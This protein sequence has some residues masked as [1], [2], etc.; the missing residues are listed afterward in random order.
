MILDPDVCIYDAVLFGNGPTNEQGDSRSRIIMNHNYTICNGVRAGFYIV[1]L[2]F[3]LV[4][5]LSTFSRMSTSPFNTC[6]ICFQQFYRSHHYTYLFDIPNGDFTFNLLQMNVLISLQHL[7][8]FVSHL[9]EPRIATMSMMV[10]L[11][12]QSTAAAAAVKLRR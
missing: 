5:S 8:T 4:I 9:L 12:A 6:I 1:L 11:V 7:A 3:L 2:I 10:A